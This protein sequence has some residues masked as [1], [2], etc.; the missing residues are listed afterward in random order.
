MKKLTGNKPMYGRRVKTKWG[1]RTLHCG[2]D[3][4]SFFDA[5]YGTEWGFI[6]DDIDHPIQCHVCGY[7]PWFY[8]QGNM[9]T[10]VKKKFAKERT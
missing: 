5:I 1:R 4:L 8:K 7:A 2:C 6:G 9:A 10:Q 3:M